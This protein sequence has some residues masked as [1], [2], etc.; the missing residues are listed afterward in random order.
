LTSIKATMANATKVELA[1]G[2]QMLGKHAA[3]HDPRTLLLANYIQPDRLPAVP[4]SA[5]WTKRVA[6]WGMMQNNTVGD[7]T[8]AAA[9][10]MIECW[11]AN[12]KSEIIPTDASIISAYATITGYDPQTGANDNGAAEIDVLNYWRQKGIGG[13]QIK[14]FVALEPKNDDQMRE[15]IYLFGGVYVGVQLP[16][17]AK[18]QSIWAVPPGGPVG[19]GAPGSW[20]GHAVPV[21][22][23]DARGLLVV[24]WGQ[25]TQM[26][27]TFWETYGDEAYAILSDDW[28]AGNAPNGFDETALQADLQSI[29]VT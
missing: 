21:V 26:T 1:N 29:G 17:S 19:T 16:N 6:Q 5:D 15:G 22:G 24:T 23:Y 11:T 2:K 14:A 7:C 13:R 25:I 28:F 3:R 27:W 10:H 20:G 12:V 8:C 18:N 4:A 9:G